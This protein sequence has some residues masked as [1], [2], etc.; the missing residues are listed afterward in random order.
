MTLRPH[1][2]DGE[3]MGTSSPD[4]RANQTV[5]IY[6]YM[7][8]KW[9]LMKSPDIYWK[10]IYIVIF[11][12]YLS[13]CRKWRCDWQRMEAYPPK[14]CNILYI[15]LHCST[16]FPVKHIRVLVRLDVQQWMHLVQG[17]FGV[18]LCLSMLRSVT[19]VAINWRI[20]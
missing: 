11:K 8:G 7:Y 3:C 9:L 5:H 1:W 17:I 18:N 2:N 13:R 20:D 14:W 19:L 12:I 15:P 16:C 6:I 4:G 10:Y